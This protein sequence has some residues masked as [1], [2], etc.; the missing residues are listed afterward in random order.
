MGLNVNQL[1]RI[2]LMFA[3]W[4]SQRIGRK[5][6]I[7]DVGAIGAL[8]PE[9]YS[10]KGEGRVVVN[11]RVCRLY[12]MLLSEQK[13]QNRKSFKMA[14]SS[15]L[16]DCPQNNCFRTAFGLIPLAYSSMK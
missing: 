10:N 15:L 2:N 14:S 1:D 11:F 12:G 16:P 9:L 3:A 7:G 4:V 6:I 13:V 5:S 8:D